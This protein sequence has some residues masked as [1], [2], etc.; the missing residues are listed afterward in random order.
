MD[1]SL[2]FDDVEILVR[3]E[4]DTMLS[5]DYVK[6]FISNV[7]EFA[8]FDM[9]DMIE[10]HFIAGVKYGISV[11]DDTTK[12]DVDMELFNIHSNFS[13]SDVYDPVQT[14][15]NQKFR[16]LFSSMFLNGAQ[17]SVNYKRNNNLQ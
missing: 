9:H 8:E 17:W 1:D 5:D 4:L 2:T 13:D 16:E 15:L 7:D 6:N 10:D 3:L 14:L 11:T 12:D